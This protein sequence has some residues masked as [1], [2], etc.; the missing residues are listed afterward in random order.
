M[1]REYIHWPNFINQTEKNLP[2]INCNWT[3]DSWLLFPLNLL[4]SFF[5]SCLLSLDLLHEGQLEHK[6]IHS[7]QSWTW[8]EGFLDHDPLPRALGIIVQKV[9]LAGP[10]VGHEGHHVQGGADWKESKY[11]TRSY[12]IINCI[13]F[14]IGRKLDMERDLFLAFTIL[15]YF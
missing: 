9:A 15:S 7:L 14:I 8:T 6:K 10:V 12:K 13:T 3:T 4:S 1:S 11:C 5:T 2:Q